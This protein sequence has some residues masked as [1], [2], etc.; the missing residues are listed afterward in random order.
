ML[1]LLSESAAG[2]GYLLEDRVAD[3]D[4]FIE[5]IRRVAAGRS[6]LDPE[7]VSQTIGRRRAT[8]PLDELTPREREVLGLM[9]HEHLRQ[10][11]LPATADDHRRVLGVVA[12]LRA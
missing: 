2:V 7:V 1:D 10:A 4:R 5:A 3:I 12:Y 9:A 6:A 8:D 11:R